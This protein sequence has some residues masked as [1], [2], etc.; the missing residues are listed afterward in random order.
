MEGLRSKTA[1]VFVP[2]HMP[3]REALERTTHLAV[4]AHQDDIELMAYAGIVECYG[5]G[6]QWFTGLTVS[7]G[8]GCRLTGPYAG[9]TPEQIGQIRNREQKKAAEIG[10]YSCAVLLGYSSRQVCDPACTDVL[11]D[12][13]A[14]VCRAKPRLV[15]THNLADRHKTHVAVALR[16]IEAIRRLPPGAKPEKLYGCEGWRSLDWM[17][18]GDKV[19][20]DVSGHP[21]LR[22]ALLGVFDSQIDGGKR[23]DLAGE[24]RRRANAV[25]ADPYRPDKGEAV[26]LAMDLTPLIENPGLDIQQ[27]VAS[28]IDRFAKDITAMLSGL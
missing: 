28:Y 20:I 21:N 5:R 19:I 6:D 10:E 7:D 24:G 26:G 14:L 1:E 16:T 12:I 8:T 3:L 27:Y 9:Y 11:E 25:F 4:G 13:G 17:V 18:E 23:Y 22:Q 15:Y 2:D